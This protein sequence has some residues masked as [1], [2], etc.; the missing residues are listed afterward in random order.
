MSVKKVT[1]LGADGTPGPGILEGLLHNNF[2][3]TILKRENSKSKDDYPPGVQVK[4]VS[5]KFEV[6][7]VTEAI[8]DQDGVVVAIKGGQIDIQENIA[9]ACINAK[10]KRF[11]PADF[12]SC[13]SSTERA[14]KLAP[15]YKAK[16]ELRERLMKL[17]KE[18]P[19]FSW[20]SLVCGHF[21]DWDPAFLH[22]WV[23]ERK[24]DV[25]DDGEVRWST[26]T[27]GRTGEATARIFL[28]L[29]ATKNKMIFVQ[30]FCVSENEVVKAYEKASG[31]KFEVNK[32]KATEYEEQEK[33]KRDDGDDDAQENLVW[34]LGTEDAN[35]ENRDTFAMKDLG[36]ENEDLDTVVKGI[37]SRFQ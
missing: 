15:F 7:E 27:L 21:F 6:D 19:D 37:V 18:N 32:L 31:A 4:K 17:A 26:S 24:A 10:V 20:T 1:L 2:E 12:G 8:H 35:W 16:T 29:E 36:L 28:N 34:I 30:S 33:K 11:I 22:I 13:D 23:K 3:V 14:G 25:L 9:R 5:E